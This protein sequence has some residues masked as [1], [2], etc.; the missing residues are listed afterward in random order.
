M[1]KYKIYRLSVWLKAN[2]YDVPTDKEYKRTR[3][4][5]SLRALEAY[6]ENHSHLPIKRYLIEEGEVTWAILAIRD[7]Q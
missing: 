3:E 2:R 6:L 5:K 1:R 7:E 4:F